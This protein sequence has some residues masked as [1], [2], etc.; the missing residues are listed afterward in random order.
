M[1]TF[2]NVL[3]VRLDEETCGPLGSC[4]GVIAS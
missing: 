1:D 4:I 3:S 2:E